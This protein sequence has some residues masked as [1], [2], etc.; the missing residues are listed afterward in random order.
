MASSTLLIRNFIKYLIVQWP[1]GFE[2]ALQVHLDL[3]SIKLNILNRYEAHTTT[4]HSSGVFSFVNKRHQNTC[5]KRSYSRDRQ[6]VVWF[7]I[8][9]ES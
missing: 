9:C 5:K 8:S 3:L 6:S 4:H 7:N 2:I 1:L